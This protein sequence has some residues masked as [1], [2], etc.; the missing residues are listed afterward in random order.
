M[1]Q[2][3]AYISVRPVRVS[4]AIVRQEIVEPSIARN[5]TAEITACLWHDSQ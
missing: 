3:T 4:D 1:L 2:R 5:A